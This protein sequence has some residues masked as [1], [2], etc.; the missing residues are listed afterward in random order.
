MAINTLTKRLE[1]T[2]PKGGTVVSRTLSPNEGEPNDVKSSQYQGATPERNTKQYPTT[3]TSPENMDIP[4]YDDLVAISSPSE[5]VR[6][7]EFETVVDAQALHKSQGGA[8]I[9][10]WQ[11]SSANIDAPD[12]TTRTT[13]EIG[14]YRGTVN[15]KATL[16]VPSY[17]KSPGAKVYTDEDNRNISMMSTGQVSIHSPISAGYQAG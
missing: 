14:N 11:M 13:M 9:P 1:T 8:I 17:H 2:K 10:E 15:D 5:R 16:P 12:A 7:A 3:T 4:C 6:P